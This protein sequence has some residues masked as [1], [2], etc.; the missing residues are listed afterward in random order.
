MMKRPPKATLM[1]RYRW[2]P[3]QLGMGALA[4]THGKKGTTLAALRV[5][6][7]LPFVEGY[8]T[9]MESRLAIMRSGPGSSGLS[10]VCESP[11]LRE[12]PRGS[13]SFIGNNRVGE[14]FILSISLKSN[15]DSDFYLD[16]DAE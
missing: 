5:G 2:A 15:T 1:L 8:P 9:L 6:V 3:S 12:Y 11:P 10:A 16:L 14:V 4:P 7:P 13:V